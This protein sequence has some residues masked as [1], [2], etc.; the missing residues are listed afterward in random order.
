VNRQIS[1]VAIVAL[2][3]LAA[4][5]VATT[6]WQ[7]WEAPT[8]A[9]KQ[10]NA[11]QR[12]AQ[13]TI[14]R[15][16][17]Y[18]SDGK[19]VLAANTAK[20]VGG[21]TLYFR[22]YPTHGLASQVVGYSTQGRSRAGIEREENAYLT[23]SNAN[24]GTIFEK[25]AD[26]VKGTTVKG[27]NLVLNLRVNAQK[28]AESDLAGK[29]GAAVVLNPKT[30]QVYVMASSPGYD[31]NKI[32]SD[33]GYASI[34]HSPQACPG[35]SSALYNRATQGLYPPGSTFKT[36]TAA[37]ALDDK[38]Y[39]LTSQFD[40][41]GYCTE[42]GKQISNALNPEGSAEAYGNV[43]LLQAYE[44]SIN[45]VFCNIGQKLGA[46]KIIDKAKDFGF[47]SKPPIELPSGEVAP[48]GEYSPR[49]T[50]FTDPHLMDPGRLAFGQDK[51]IVTP[52][53]MALVAAAV[54]DNGTIMEPHLV[55]RVT[56][57]GGGTVTKIKPHVWKHA[58]K[59]STAAALNQMMQAVV[60][61]GTGTSAQIPGVKVAGKTGT[62]ET[63]LDRVYDAWF[64]F[65]APADNPTVAG[66]VVVEHADDGFGGSVSAPIAKDLM[67][68]ILG[69]TAKK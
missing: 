64:I 61:G 67:Q 16:L 30:G 49:R 42:Y 68:A 28:I 37:A 19:T 39:T 38:T 23:A 4:L 66:A 62:A 3:L 27:N 25:I 48:S 51:L 52:L 33:K 18:A 43:D 40:D 5:V 1:R 10:D 22:R 47:Y 34:I 21:Q 65:F 55:N 11:I 24:L 63:G 35:S 13:F 12:V 53:Q 54:A 26:S 44:H 60:T 57:P 31:P 14:R 56:S 50:P 20:K 41:P 7:S 69:T 46:K 17:I 59:P 29:C 15:G 32:E 2:L 36:V 9:A 45:A 8:L 58:M 6:Y